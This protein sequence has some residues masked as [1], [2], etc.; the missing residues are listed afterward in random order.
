[1]TNASAFLGVAA[2]AL[3]AT[4]SCASTLSHTAPV[5]TPAGVRFAL[6]RPEATTVAI[7]GSFNQWSPTANPLTRER[8]RSPWSAVVQLPPGE[9]L[10]MFVINGT[11][12]ISPPFAVDYV[13]DGFGAQNGVVV[14]RATG[15]IEP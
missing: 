9:H 15:A 13:D 8:P 3:I 7:A 11:E 12:W 14:V 4:L 6:Q 5:V 10:F 1:M 2:F